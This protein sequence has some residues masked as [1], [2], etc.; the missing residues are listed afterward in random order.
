MRPAAPWLPAPC[1]LGQVLLSHWAKPEPEP[2]K[3]PVGGAVEQQAGV[4]N[5]S[6]PGL[7]RVLGSNWEALVQTLFRVF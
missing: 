2:S 1:L 3:K 5:R 4:H 7:A 6:G